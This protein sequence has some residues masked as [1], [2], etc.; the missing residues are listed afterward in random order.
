[1]AATETSGKEFYH[2]RVVTALVMFSVIWAVLGMSAGVY[3][4]AELV[5]P[6]LDFGQSASDTVRLLDLDRIIA[7]FL[8]DGA[9]LADGLGPDLSTFA[10]VFSFLGTGGEEEV[11][12]VA[13]TEC[14]RLPRSITRH[15]GSSTV[16]L[17]SVHAHVASSDS[18]TR[19]RT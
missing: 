15:H 1:M 11:R 10:F 3:I 9:D 17:A 4:A 19:G 6:T 8:C 12:V 16:L 13:A 5:W 18:H 7:T 2:D 14:D